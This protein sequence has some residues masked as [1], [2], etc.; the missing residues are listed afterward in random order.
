VYAAPYTV[1]KITQDGRQVYTARPDTRR[2][3]HERDALM[4]NAQ[5]HK[6]Y[7]GAVSSA[8]AAQKTPQTFFTAGAGGG[9]TRRTVWSTGLDSRLALT[10]V[11]FA[12]RPGEKKD[13]TVPAQLPNNPAPA[14]SA[15]ETAAQIWQLAT[16]GTGQAGQS[17]TPAL[18]PTPHRPAESPQGPPCGLVPKACP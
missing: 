14:E 4:V 7:K 17:R 5:M 1:T 3:M 16:T 2:S 11:L 9:I 13:T 8:P 18:A 12:D 10:V 6:M 15:E